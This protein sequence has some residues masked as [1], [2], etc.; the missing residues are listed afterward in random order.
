MANNLDSEA[1]IRKVYDDVTNTLKTSGGAGGTQYA[2][3]T[4]QATPTGTVAL[5][6]T[7]A[8][9]VQPL[10]LDASGNLKINLAAGSISGNAS[11]STTGA[12]VPASADYIGFNSSGNLTGVSSAN[13]LPVSQQGSLSVTG[14]FY[15]ATQPVSIASMPSTPVTGTF[16]QATQPVSG[17]VSVSNF[18]ATQPVS[19]ATMPSTPVTGT[20]WQTTQ[21]VSLASM[22]STPVTGTFWQATQPVSGTVTANQGAGTLTNDLA[23]AAITTTA[24]TS[25]VVPTVGSYV[26]N[27]PVTVVSG[28]TPTLDVEVQESDDTGTNWY[29]VYDFPRITAT[30]MYRSPVL[31]LTG[32]RVR[33]VQTLT[34]TTPSFTRALNRVQLSTSGSPLRQIIDRSIVLTTLNSSTP[35]LI[36]QSTKNVQL[37]INIGTAG[38]PPAIQI[39]GSDDAGA[40]WYSVGT[41]L[42]A[43]ASSTVQLTVPNV[44]SQLYRATVSTIGVTVVAGYVLLRAF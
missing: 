18:P 44:T 40:T 14:A 17:T 22:P 7:A 26:V 8:N 27:I 15:Q 42:T 5:G 30:G 37:V 21:P 12:A 2:A 25:A 13:P 11:A 20:F 24:T 34:G 3:G 36:G 43:V 39:Q 31:S 19:I 41:P 1:I 10:A 4:T 32:N 23:A 28:T 6:A 33:Y 16:F 35:N 38:T 9:V 29:A